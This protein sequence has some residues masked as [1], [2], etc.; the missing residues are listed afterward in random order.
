MSGAGYF[1][2][3]VY[4]NHEVFWGILIVIYPY[5]VS[6]ITGMVTVY[7][8]AEFWRKELKDIEKLVVVSSLPFVLSALLPLLLDLGQPQRA[9]E[10]YVTPNFNSVMAVFGIVYLTEL[11]TLLGEMWFLFRIDIINR[12]LNERNPVMR[13]IYR[14]LTLGVYDTSEEA[15]KIDKK[16]IKVLTGIELIAAWCLSYVSFLFGVVKSNPW[17][18][19][20]IL[21]VSFVFGGLAAGGAMVLLLY[22][23][24]TKYYGISRKFEV[25]ST[26]S[27]YVFYFLLAAFALEMINTILYA[28]KEDIAWA[29]IR[30]ASTQLAIPL[31]IQIVGSL[32]A[33]LF[34]K[35]LSYKSKNGTIN[36]LFII[37]SC[38]TI[39]VVVFAMR[40]NMVIGAQ[41]IDYSLRG[42]VSYTPPLL[43]REGLL[44]A[45]G[46]L[47]APFVMLPVVTYFFPPYEKNQ[48]LTYEMGLPFLWV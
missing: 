45:L 18:N 32:E 14:I 42:F 31:V 40:W 21:P 1:E 2:G 37:L 9:F 38:I 11:L 46:V 30:L 20:T 22:I 43:G 34:L 27:N 17:W 29:V 10:I 7:A 16:V 13:L 15:R 41:L 19:T 28:Y 35:Y 33:M 4:P 25:V 8:I 44:A 39:L 6:I 36:T 48:C 26:V 23:V 24:Y 47:L 12:A 3:F 5:F